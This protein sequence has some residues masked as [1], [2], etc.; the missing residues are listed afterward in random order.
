VLFYSTVT[1]GWKSTNESFASSQSLKTQVL[2]KHL[3]YARVPKLNA[4]DPVSV[5][6]KMYNY[7]GY[8][9]FQYT[10]SPQS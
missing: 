3:F 9:P 7:F 4:Q 6:A 8:R 1:L 2:G 10:P 5:T